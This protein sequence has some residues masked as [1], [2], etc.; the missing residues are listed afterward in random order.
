MVKKMPRKYEIQDIFNFQVGGDHDKPYVTFLHTE[1]ENIP[2]G[3][4]HVATLFE[5]VRTCEL[6]EKKLLEENGLSE[7]ICFIGSLS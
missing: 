3:L 4:E 5:N 1:V 7:N 6:S 2:M